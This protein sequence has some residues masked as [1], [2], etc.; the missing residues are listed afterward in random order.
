MLLLRKILLT[1]ATMV[2]VV[3]IKNA[4]VKKDAV[5]CYYNDC[6]GDCKEC[7]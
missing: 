1:A 5:D 6:G 4:I 7:W 2:A 3:T